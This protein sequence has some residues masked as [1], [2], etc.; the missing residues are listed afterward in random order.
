MKPLSFLLLGLIYLIS[1]LAGQVDDPLRNAINIREEMPELAISL[2]DSIIQHTP[3]EETPLLGVAWNVK[4]T[5]HRDRGMYDLSENAYQQ[6]IINYESRKDTLGIAKVQNNQSQLWARRKNYLSAQKLQE[7]ALHLFETRPDFDSFSTTYIS[8]IINLGNIYEA[9]DSLSMAAVAY[10]R[11]ATLAQASQY[12]EGLHNAKENLAVVYLKTEKVAQARDLLTECLVYYEKDSSEW[13]EAA[14]KL[15]T[16]HYLLSDYKQAKHYL[17]QSELYAEGHD[18]HRLLAESSSTLNTIALEENNQIKTWSIILLT[19]LLL[20]I[21]YIAYQRLQELKIKQKETNQKLAKQQEQQISAENRFKRLEV[22]LKGADSVLQEL[23]SFIH[24]RYTRDANQI[25]NILESL[26]SKL[27]GFSIDLSQMVDDACVIADQAYD[28]TRS[29][30]YAVKPSK[31]RWENWINA[32][33]I[34]LVLD[35]KVELNYSTHGV[36]ED[37]YDELTANRIF[38]L[39]YNLINNIRNHAKADKIDIE[40]RETISHLY[41]IVEDNGVGFHPTKD[42]GVG[43]KSV[44]DI[45]TK[46]KGTLDIKSIPDGI[47]GTKVHIRIPLN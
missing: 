38:D 11:A 2:L 45:V 6:A 43:L 12:T 23:A 7:S 1:P 21:G 9:R 15:G 44:E 30:S 18:Q 33:I 19:L 5:I 8:S 29:T 32:Q 34:G 16:A 40:I 42:K 13:A 41:I 4:A 25:K 46:L 31:V 20:A 35:H 47:E 28:Y 22:V 37:S 27:G 3:K 17:R 36:E 26:R 39:L 10:K 14:H 24:N